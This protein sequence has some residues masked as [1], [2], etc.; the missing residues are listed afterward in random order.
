[1]LD[2]FTCLLLAAFIQL[3]VNAH[4]GGDPRQDWKR[5]DPSCTSTRLNITDL[6]DFTFR[7]G[8]TSIVET[9]VSVTS[10]STCRSSN[11]S[12]VESTLSVTRSSTF[13]TSTP[14]SLR[15]SSSDLTTASSSIGPIGIIT[16][17]DTTT[18]TSTHTQTITTLITR[19][20]TATASL[21][22]SS[23]SSQILS[24]RSSLTSTSSLSSSSASSSSPSVQRI[25][26]P[27]GTLAPDDRFVNAAYFTNWSVVINSILAELLT[28]LGGQLIEIIILM[29]CP[30]IN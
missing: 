18:L 20:S 10:S 12:I 2:T 8:N 25:A 19:N 16:E 29:I 17:T 23:T 22:I 5:A 30:L 28:S 15:T 27:A 6:P 21:N 3:N 1:M 13:S 24:V 26:L 14:A 11:T 9:T 4:P 7:P